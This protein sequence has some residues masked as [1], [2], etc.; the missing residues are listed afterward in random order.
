MA[1]EQAL[2]NLSR[3]MGAL[4]Q[5]L[6]DDMRHL[7]PHSFTCPRRHGHIGDNGRRVKVYLSEGHPVYV[8]CPTCKHLFAVYASRGRVSVMDLGLEE[9]RA[10]G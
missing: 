3:R 2:D 8:V 10:T 9:A 5:Q 7:A 1:A 6:R 4:T